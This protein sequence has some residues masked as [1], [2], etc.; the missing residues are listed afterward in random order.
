MKLEVPWSQ[1]GMRKSW[2][3]LYTTDKSVY[4]QKRER[5]RV[6]LL[7][8]TA[9]DSGH[10]VSTRETL[11]YKYS[12]KVLLCKLH[13]T[14]ASLSTTD[15]RYT[16]LPC[17]KHLTPLLPCMIRGSAQPVPVRKRAHQKCKIVYCFVLVGGLADGYLDALS[18]SHTH[19]HTFSPFATLFQSLQEHHSKNST[20]SIFPSVGGC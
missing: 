15:Y 7:L 1:L 8:C 12:N 19:T 6:R 9:R 17:N 18:V 10:F 20:S 2:Q 4:T 14:A 5:E 16:S 3:Q 11:Q 13:E